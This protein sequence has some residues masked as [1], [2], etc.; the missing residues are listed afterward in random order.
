[1]RNQHYS[2]HN[3]R[4]ERGANGRNENWRSEDRDDRGRFSGSHSSSRSEYGQY[5]DED[6]NGRQLG[7][8]NEPSRDEDG[9]FTSDYGRGSND[10]WMGGT[11]FG[12]DNDERENNAS[13]RGSAHADYHHWRAGEIQRMDDEYGDYLKDRRSKFNDD[14]SKWR[15][16]KKNTSSASNGESS[17]AAKK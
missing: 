6:D 1:M 14:F 11:A 3:N 10:E 12:R 5:E 8:N 9:R 13:H 17:S 16:N 4:S 15:E 7:R 2:Q